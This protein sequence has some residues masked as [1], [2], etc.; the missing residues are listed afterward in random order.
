MN[1]FIAS[2]PLI[3]YFAQNIAKEKEENILFFWC[4]T[5]HSKHFKSADLLFDSK[6]WE[7]K[8]FFEDAD[9]YTKI[10]KERLFF[11]SLAVKEMERVEYQIKQVFESYPIKEIFVGNRHAPIDRIFVEAAKKKGCKVHLIEDGLT[12]YLDFKYYSS[13]EKNSFKR[14]FWKEKIKKYYY[15][16]IKRE[17]IFLTE[18]EILFDDIFA[19]FPEKYHLRNYKSQVQKINFSEN[20]KTI[21]LDLLRGEPSYDIMHDKNKKN[22][23]F[24]SQSLSEDG[25]LSMDLEVKFI[26]QYLKKYTDS[27]NFRVFFKPHPRDS[28]EKINAFN[29]NINCDNF[30]ILKNE[31]P[32]PV[33][34][35]LPYMNV[36]RL[37]GTWSAAL[38]YTNI[39]DPSIET[40]SILKAILDNS[41]DSKDELKKLRRIYDTISNVFTDEVIWDDYK[42]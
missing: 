6:I 34:I 11:P 24:L 13:L 33:E 23:L 20:K 2:S 32:L 30:I 39:I 5:E 40:V 12:N 37:I 14:E 36:S 3:F 10:N 29:T 19:V 38:F 22:I 1:L 21:F 31:I 27:E 15:Q 25:L 26:S 4:S 41:V 17:N 8:I 35:L 7:R 16:R 9:E 42:N 18:N 28:I